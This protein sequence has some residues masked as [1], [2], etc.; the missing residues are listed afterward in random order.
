[1]ATIE[2]FWAPGVFDPATY[3]LDPRCLE[4][5]LARPP[6]GTP[7]AVLPVHLY[8]QPADMPAIAL[9]Y[10]FFE[11]EGAAQMASA[12]QDSKGFK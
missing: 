3:T 2:R 4:A 8:G 6:A 7:K 10:T 9:S 1:M 11:V 5:V 12:N